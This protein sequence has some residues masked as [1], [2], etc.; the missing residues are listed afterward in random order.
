MLAELTG[1][2]N[3][4]EVNLDDDPTANLISNDEVL[5]NPYAGESFEEDNLYGIEWGEVTSN[6]YDIAMT[7]NAHI[8]SAD[9]LVLAKSFHKSNLTI[10][11]LTGVCV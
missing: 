3:A 10:F 1:M 8:I 4:L 11:S 6:L 9:P 2:V 5:Q 7:N